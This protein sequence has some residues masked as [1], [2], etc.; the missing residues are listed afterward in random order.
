MNLSI[1]EKIGQRFIFGI[2]DENID[3]II[4]LIEKASIGGVVLYKKNYN[5]YSHM[6]EVIKKLKDAN[7]NNKLP[8]FIAVDQEGGRVN[9][10]PNDVHLLKNIYDVSKCD[11]KLVN[12]YAKINSKMLYNG[13]INMNLAP[14]IDVYNDSKSGV[15][16]KRCFYGDEREVSFLGKSYISEFK[17]HKVIPVIKHFPGHGASKFDSHLMIPYIFNYQELLDKHMKP[18]KDIICNGC[19]AIMVG[20]LVVRRLTNGL[21]ASISSDFIKKYLRDGYDGLIMTDELN[22]L[23]RHLF[24]RFIYMNKALI[25]GN[26]ILLVKIKNFNEGYRIINKYK[27][28]LLNNQKYI[29]NLDDSVMRI[30]NIK[31]KYNINDDIKVND[32]RLDDIN[33]EID[34]LNERL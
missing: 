15:L 5:S 30:I 2:N 29:D 13:G 8:L 27:S 9:R 20:H 25:S 10:M 28:L 7:K 24:Y 11:S 22:M 23:R 12:D 32:I 18:F 21:P 4:Q 17:N 14:V 33:R 3:C 19:D 1:D 16:Y 26:D 31:N 6:L 34:R